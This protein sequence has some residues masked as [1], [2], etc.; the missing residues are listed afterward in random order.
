MICLRFTKRDILVVLVLPVC[1]GIMFLRFGGNGYTFYEWLLGTAE[2]AE[3]LT[4]SSHSFALLVW[5]YL[6]FLLAVVVLELLHKYEKGKYF[7]WG[8][9]ASILLCMIIGAVEGKENSICIGMILL[10][11]ISLGYWLLPSELR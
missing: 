5:I 4:R 11:L 7:A 8:N 3:P 6:V 1:V 2:L 9:T 10:T